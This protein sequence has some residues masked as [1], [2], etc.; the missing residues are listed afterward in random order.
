MSKEDRK[1]NVN[2]YYNALAEKMKNKVGPNSL[3]TAH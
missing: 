3:Y 2:E 1:R